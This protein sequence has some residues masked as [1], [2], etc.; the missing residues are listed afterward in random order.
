MF[1]EKHIRMREDGADAIKAPDQPLDEF[2]DQGNAL[3]V[4]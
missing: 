1:R 4:G 2:V 3:L